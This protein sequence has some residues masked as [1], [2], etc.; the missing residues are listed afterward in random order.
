M[1]ST[2]LFML[3]MVFCLTLVAIVA[4]GTNREKVALAALQI[5]GKFLDLLG[6]LPFKKK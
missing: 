4:L 2:T 1:D 5:H 6:G 3:F